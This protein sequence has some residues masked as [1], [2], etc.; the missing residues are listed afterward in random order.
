MV[1][2]LGDESVLLVK[3]LIGNKLLYLVYCHGAV[4]PA[5]GAL[6]LTSAVAYSA[7]YRGERVFLLDKLKRIRISALRRKLDIA[8]NGDMRGAGGLAGGCARLGDV[9]S[10]AS[11]P[12]IP[13]V[14]SPVEVIRQLLHGILNGAVLRTELLTH[15]DRVVGAG[16]GA[17]SAC[18]ALFL[19]DLRDIVA[20]RCRRRVV[21]LRH[22][23]RKA[24]LGLAVAYRERLPLLDGGDLMHAADILGAFNKLVGLFLSELFSS[25]EIDEHIGGMSHEQTKALVQIARALTHELS[26]AAALTRQSAEMVGV[27]FYVHADL[28]VVY[29]LSVLGN[30][31]LNG[32]NAHDARTH[33]RVHRMLDLARCGVLFKGIR[34]LGMCAAEFLVYQKKFEYAGCIK[35]QKVELNIH[36][37][38]QHLHQKTYLGQLVHHRASLLLFEPCPFR[39]VC[40]EVYLHRALDSHKQSYLLVG[41]PFFKHSVLRA[42]RSYLIVP[43]VYSFA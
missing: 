27:L 26:H 28:L 22:A 29:L 41:Y 43:V 11:E 16:I 30:G 39:N 8:L 2:L 7:A 9:A 40:K 34:Y 37:R 20:L 3:L 35:R 38:N 31:A 25:A 24:A 18:N 5:A 23:E 36:L 4:Y 14:G 17:H 42:V 15:L 13:S 1:E 21:I 32:D 6:I 33:G 19:V 12:G 10:L